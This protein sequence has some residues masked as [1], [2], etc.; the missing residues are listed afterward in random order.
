MSSSVPPRG[1]SHP[2]GLIGGPL[3]AADYAMLERCGIGKEAAE[4]A[5]LRRVDSE[6]GGQVVGRNGSSNYSGLLFAYIWPGEQHVRGHRVRRDFPELE[7]GKQKNKY[8]SPPGRGNMLYFAPGTQPEWLSDKSIP[9]VLTEGEKKCISLYE[10]AWH[11]LSESAEKPQFLPVAI[12][13]VWNWKGRIGKVDGPNGE[14][15]DEVGPI[16]DFARITWKKRLVKFVFDSN[17]LSNESVKVARS[18]FAKHLRKLEAK[19][20]FVDIPAEPGVNGVDDLVGI[21]GT[22]RVL[23]LIANEAYDP[24]KRARE[25]RAGAGPKWD[26]SAALV[27]N[28]ETPEPSPGFDEKG[29]LVG[30][31]PTIGDIL[32]CRY[33]FAKNDG[34]QLYIFR[35][36][37]YRPEASELIRSA[38]RGLMIEW[39]TKGSWKSALAHEINE[40]VT[41]PSPKLWERPPLNRINLLNGILDL[42]S[43]RL[44][45]H[46]PNWLSPVQLPVIY[47]PSAACPQWESFLESVL[48]QD[49]FEAEVAFQLVALLMIPFTS[50][51]RALLLRGPRGTGKSRFLTGL[52]AFLGPENTS[53][54]SLHALEENRFTTAYLY[55]K[56]ANIC[57]DL[58][59]HDLESTSKFK[60]ITGEDYLDG[61]Y[62]HGRQFQFRPFSR[63]L[64]SANEPPTSKDATDAFL[65]RWWVVPF[66][67]RFQD[68]AGQIPA[69]ELDGRLSRPSELSGVL[70]RALSLLPDV[71][72]RQ[73]ITQTAAMRTAH[74]DF[75]ATTDPFRVWLSE[76]VEDDPDA[77]TPCDDVRGSYFQFRRARNLSSITVSAFGLELKKHKRLEEPKQRTVL[78]RNGTPWCYLGIRLKPKETK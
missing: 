54:K 9:V 1:A 77:V 2:E 33:Q 44:T 21:W 56:L 50:A 6:T 24:K 65:D 23:D 36:G 76:Y 52:R 62:K 35:D 61:E 59:T 25:E 70:N 41:I 63:L 69:A 18:A 7:N 4:R 47:D 43:G 19:V 78:G 42:E 75:C 11:G 60:A 66:E 73:G 39:Q 16:P 55:G 26:P 67:N 38:G 40:W 53:S 31:A 68:N 29:R 14:R 27:Q 58:P 10:V 74:D 37:A 72:G 28:N 49:V 3:T 34:D 5:L 15:L 13:G 22:Q 46:T 57:A 32:L 71:L 51:Q 64:F 45:P 30:A 8:L 12:S 17:V 48:P 20:L